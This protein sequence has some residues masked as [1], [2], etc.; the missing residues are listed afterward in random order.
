MA[1]SSEDSDR[2]VLYRDAEGRDS[3]VEEKRIQR[4]D[5][6]RKWTRMFEVEKDSGVLLED[7][8]LRVDILLDNGLAE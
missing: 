7:G 3:D 6:W 1:D 4:V 5:A 8:G 2:D